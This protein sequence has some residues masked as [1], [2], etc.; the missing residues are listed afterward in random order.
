MIM[1]V[2]SRARE[3]EGQKTQRCNF[4][5]WLA[6]PPRSETVAADRHA[7]ESCCGT[8]ADPYDARRSFSEGFYAA[9]RPPRRRRQPKYAPMHRLVATP[10]SVPGSGTACDWK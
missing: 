2:G 9:E 1:G 3:Q 4:P 5:M 10:A 6:K 7:E 8:W